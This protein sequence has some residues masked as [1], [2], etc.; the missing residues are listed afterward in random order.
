MESIQ[1]QFLVEG[2]NKLKLEIMNQLET[3]QDHE[4]MYMLDKCSKLEQY[5][6]FVF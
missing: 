3:L 4:E 6:S 2:N 1:E 5:H